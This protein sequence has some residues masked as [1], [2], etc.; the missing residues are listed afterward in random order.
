MTLSQ[1]LRVRNFAGEAYADA[2]IYAGFGDGFLK[3][4]GT[5][6][7]KQMLVQRVE[8]LPVVKTY[9]ANPAAIGWL[10]RGQQKLRVQMHYRLHNDA[11]HGL[12]AAALP[13]GKVRIFQ[14]DAADAAATT[15]FLGEDVASHTAVG[16]HADLFLGIA[17]DVVVRR[18][19][20]R[21]DDERVAGNLF[22]RSVTLKYEIGNF[23]DQPVTLNLVE[24]IEP[25]RQELGL[26]SGQPAEWAL[27]PATS[28]A[29][30]PVAEATDQ[31]QVTHRVDLP[32]RPADGAE[33][34]KTVVLLEL[35]FR[36][37]W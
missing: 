29:G 14:K 24:M 22:H 11:E 13:P 31:T 8:G 26:Q 3:P 6:Q 34:P 1:Y 36:N 15:A 25:L 2:E 37:Q 4:I 30:G 32:A 18:T 10:D 27:G 19:V 9:T 20:E 28:F 33:P 35:I 12:G 5:N 7:T 21:R 16:D 23:K 17:Q